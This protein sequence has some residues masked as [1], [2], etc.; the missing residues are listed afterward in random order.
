[1]YKTVYYYHP[2]TLSSLSWLS[3]TLDQ[4]RTRE[5]FPPIDVWQSHPLLS[6]TYKSQCDQSSMYRKENIPSLI[7]EVRTV[8]MRK[9]DVQTNFRCSGNL[10]YL[11]EWTVFKDLFYF[12]LCLCVGVCKWMKAPLKAGRGWKNSRS[13]EGLWAAQCGT[14]EANLRSFLEQLI[15]SNLSR[16]E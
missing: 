14:S 11:Y 12:T 7:D 8:S 9:E 13:F 16:L 5:A 15:L 10:T 2:L 1:M 3:P 4:T 6:L